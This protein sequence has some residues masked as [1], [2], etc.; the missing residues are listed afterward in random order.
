MN[1]K[2][3]TAKQAHL[4]FIAENM[5]E[6]DVLELKAFS[7]HTPIEAL[8]LSL[9]R[10]LL[11]WVCLVDNKPA[12]IWGV[13][14]S[15]SILSKAGIPWLL[16]TPDIYKARF[17]L[18]KE[19]RTYVGLMKSTFETLENYVHS[20]N[21]FSIRWLRWSGFKIEKEAKPWGIDK[22]ELFYRFYS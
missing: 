15:G 1:I 12:F 14:P 3:V 17:S 2:V 22:N 8:D 10:S 9:N 18:L 21:K 7:G 4:S 13:A 19:S 20:K 5:R 16:G 6:A 11:S